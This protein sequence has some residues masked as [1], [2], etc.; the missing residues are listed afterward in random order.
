MASPGAKISTQIPTFEKSLSLSRYVEDA[1]VIAFGARAG[2]WSQASPYSF[3]AATT[4]TIPSSMRVWIKASSTE[5]TPPP[6]LKLT[7]AGLLYV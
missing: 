2:E 7:T 1:T 6:R 5:F 4:V 3:P